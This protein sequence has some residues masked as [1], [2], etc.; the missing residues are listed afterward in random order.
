MHVNIELIRSKLWKEHFIPC[1]KISHFSNSRRDDNGVSKIINK[2]KRTFNDR[3]HVD[4]ILRYI[5]CRAI[6]GLQESKVIEIIS[7]EK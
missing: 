3:E 5:P 6:D 1:L 2:K 7:K 4:E